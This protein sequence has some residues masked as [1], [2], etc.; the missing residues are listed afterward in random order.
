MKKN[1]SKIDKELQDRYNQLLEESKGS[2]DFLKK[3]QSI[4]L[5][6]VRELGISTEPTIVISFNE[7]KK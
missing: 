3:C 1:N 6:E 5:K 7:K 2:K 4:S